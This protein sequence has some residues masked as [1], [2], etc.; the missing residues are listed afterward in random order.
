M[1]KVIVHA[2]G[3]TDRFQIVEQPDPIPGDNQVVVRLTSIGMNYADIM[4]RRGEYN[5]FILISE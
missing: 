1:H 5:K 2:F 3:G 4:A